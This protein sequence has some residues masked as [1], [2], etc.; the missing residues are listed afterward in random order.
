[1]KIVKEGDKGKA[2]CQTCGLTET[3]YRLRDVAFSDNSGIVKNIL[4]G[5]CDKCDTV[6]SVP[7]QCTPKI[8]SA[9]NETKKSAEYRVPAHFIDILSLAASKIDYEMGDVLSKPLLLYY[10]HKLN[11]GVISGAKLKELLSS[12]LASAPSSKRLSLKITERT[13]RELSHVVEKTGLHNN[14]DVVKGIILKIYED[15]VEPKKPK[16]LKELKS[17][18]A[19]F[20]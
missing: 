4:A 2:V 16:H 3:T 19:A 10:V 11:S 17:I 5:V 15:I 6:T 18:A 13:E 7:R 14:T 9:Y 8:K 20:G 12:D 1:M